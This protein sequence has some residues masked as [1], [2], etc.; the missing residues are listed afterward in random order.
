MGTAKYLVIIAVVAALVCAGAQAEKAS[1]LL[2]EAVYT[3][4]VVGD[5]D[6]AIEAY[7]EVISA[8]DATDRCLAEAHYRLGTCYLRQD[9]EDAA[10]AHFRTVVRDFADRKA[11]AGKAVQAWAKTVR[12]R[13]DVPRV[14]YTGPETFA[15]DV[16]PAL[17]RITATFDRPMVDGSWSWTGGG[18]TFPQTTGKPRYDDAR[19]TC[20]LPVRLEP[21]K[22]YWVGINS[23]SHGNFQ[24]PGGVPAR[25]HVVLFATADREG[26]PTPIPEEMRRKARAINADTAP[27]ADARGDLLKLRLELIDAR[28]EMRAA[29]AE[30]EAAAEELQRV[31]KVSE[32]GEAGP[33]QVRRARLALAKADARYEA[34]VEKVEILS[35]EIQSRQTAP[36]PGKPTFGPVV[37]RL[38]EAGGERGSPDWWLD[39]DRGTTDL[40]G[41]E[42]RGPEVA[43]RRARATGADLW[44][45][46]QSARGRL[47]IDLI[48]LNTLMQSVTGAC[49]D[50]ESPREIPGLAQIAN[51]QTG[52]PPAGVPR[53]EPFPFET[54]DGW[55]DE[56][57]DADESFPATYLFKTRE[58]RAGVLQIVGFSEDPRGVRIRYKLVEE[59]ER[60]SPADETTAGPGGR[61]AVLRTVPEAF[62][63]AVSP[64]LAEMKV[65]F[66][67]RMQAGSWSWTG[68]GDTFP[69]ATGEPYYDS[70][71]ATCHLPVKLEPGKVYWVGVNSPSQ[72]NFR[73]PEG[74]PARR[75]VVL[76]ATRGADGEPTPIPD[77]LAER[78]REIN[79]DA[80][81]SLSPAEVRESEELSARAWA[82]WGQRQLSE[83]EELFEESV[84]KNP[85]NSNAWNG[86]GWARL[87]QGKPAGAR[88]AFQRC[89]ELAPRHPGALNGLG[90][91]AKG[92]GATEEAIGYWEK[93]VEAAPGATAALS[94]LATT[95][96]ESGEYDKAVRCY[97]MWLKAEPGN[98]TAKRGLQ[99]AR[100]KMSDE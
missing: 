95:Y 17:D 25:R 11:I 88:E 60:S 3:E 85:R 99:K 10:V 65:T 29:E 63:N 61:P 96:M 86:V 59:A 1:V 36:A 91:L 56:V 7:Q 76:F 50:A 70:V 80:R 77:E 43:V 34:A 37:E 46:V 31:E 89:I 57:L 90:W 30:R 97:E 21:G 6:R 15:N 74:A 78:A 45:E 100:A 83:A 87:N 39:L 93:A 44:F 67:H 41:D 98:A 23:P 73:T 58:G 20:T 68:G 47:G 71:R 14:L 84:V 55:L 54:S 40:Y 62:D 18:E 38:L 16:S 4:E 53:Q 28:A 27:G 8:G 24:T 69:E 19:M 32:L 82:L 33:G 12:P 49:W 64:E 75:Y 26:N 35:R 92:K 42:G 5:L 81:A 22:V 13:S 66:D 51:A 72:A 9:R 2:E 79:A 52:K 48:T 94:G